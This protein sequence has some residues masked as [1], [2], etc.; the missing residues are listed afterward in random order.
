MS[1][2]IGPLVDLTPDI[3]RDQSD[4]PIP[5]KPLPTDRVSPPNQL[6]ILRAWASISNEGKRPATVNE[7]SKTVDMAASTVAMTNPF[8]SSIGLLQRLAVG[9]YLPSRDVIAFFNSTDDKTAAR[10]LAPAFRD[11]W[12][13]QLILPKLKYAPM[14][15]QTVVSLLEDAAA[16]GSEQRKAVGFILDFMAAAGLIEQNGDEI[17]LTSW[18]STPSQLVPTISLDGSRYCV[19]VHVDSKEL[20]ESISAMF[21]SLSE[22]IASRK[23]GET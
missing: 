8:F 9:T 17:K 2:R 14:E 6:R 10:K 23:K 20:A 5:T 16:T 1:A 4:R 11:A 21:T 18:Y 7:V 19:T 22:L 13:G 12:F 15:E 3:L